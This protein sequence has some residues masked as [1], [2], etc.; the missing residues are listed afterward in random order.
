MSK[1]KELLGPDGEPLDLEKYRPK[2]QAG[3]IKA[4]S[5]TF[6]F[7]PRYDAGLVGRWFGLDLGVTSDKPK[8][9]R[10]KPT[11]KTTLAAAVERDV[12]TL[13]KPLTGWKGH[14]E[15]PPPPP[16]SLDTYDAAFAEARRS[17]PHSNS[18]STLHSRRERQC[19]DCG[20]YFTRKEWWEG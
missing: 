14:A 12:S 16:E 10:R 2:P 1:P 18:H 9:R 20:K 8:A 11:P 15:A 13:T 3:G 4:G 5:F 6:E 17:C 19:D 7:T